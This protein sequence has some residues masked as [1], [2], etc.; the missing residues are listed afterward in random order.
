[1]I[2]IKS[3]NEIKL[4]QESGRIA[5]LAHEAVKRAIKPG[6]TTLELD[7]IAEDIIRSH[8]AIPSFKGVR[9]MPKAIPFPG[10]ICA[11]PNEVVVHGIPNGTI[12]KEGDIISIDTGAYKNGFHSDCAKTH[13][14]GKISDTAQKLIDVTRQSFYEGIKYAKEGYRLSDIS[15][16]IENYIV[17]NGL[18]VVKDFVGHGVGTELQEEPQIPNYGRPGFGIRIKAG[19]TFAIEPMVNIGTEEVRILAD[20]WTVISADRSLSAHYEHSL[21]ITDGEP[22][23]LTVL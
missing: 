20:Q 15:S 2:T 10:T 1:M 9:G 3:Q 5:A 13:A 6:V 18:Y 21:A 19:M 17:S 11:S 7:K 16:A 4:M 8:G 14:V 23:I 22:L 12:L